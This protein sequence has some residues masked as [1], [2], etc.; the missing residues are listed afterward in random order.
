MYYVVRVGPVT[1]HNKL[2]YSRGIWHFDVQVFVISI[3]CYCIPVWNFG[4][5]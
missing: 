3:G 2:P 4:W 5:V 1:E